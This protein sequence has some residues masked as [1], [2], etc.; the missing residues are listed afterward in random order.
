MTSQPKL[1]LTTG[2][3]ELGLNDPKST[4]RKEWIKRGI[5][6]LKAFREQQ[7]KKSASTTKGDK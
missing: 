4:R 2:Q 3:P 1:P 7:E 6:L 5:N